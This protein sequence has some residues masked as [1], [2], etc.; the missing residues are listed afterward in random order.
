MDTEGVGNA[1]EKKKRNTNTIGNSANE[2]DKTK[3]DKTCL[4]ETEK[5]Y[6]RREGKRVEA[7]ANTYCCR[8]E[9]L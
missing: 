2:S 7:K 3:D 9:I 6:V 5:K 1:Q 4:N 8:L